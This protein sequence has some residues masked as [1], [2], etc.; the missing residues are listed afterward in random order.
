MIRAFDLPDAAGPALACDVRTGQILRFV[1]VSPSPVR[2]FQ[3][4][5]VALATPGEC[6]VVPIVKA[7]GTPLVTSDRPESW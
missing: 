7:D 6:Y 2:E 4:G 1:Y 5:L 3:C